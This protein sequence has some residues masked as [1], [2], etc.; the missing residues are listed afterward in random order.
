MH[1]LIKT[2]SEIK[3]IEV[4]DAEILIKEDLPRSNYADLPSD[5][6][7]VKTFDCIK[8]CKRLFYHELYDHNRRTGRWIEIF[9]IPDFIKDEELLQKKGIKGNCSMTSY[10]EHHNFHVTF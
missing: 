5:A 9:D 3:A 1:D 10:I 4:I 7:K 6:V 2:T 8:K